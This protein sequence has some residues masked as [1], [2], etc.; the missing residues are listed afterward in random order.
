MA[1]PA[2]ISVELG[3]TGETGAFVLDVSVL[4]GPA[5]LGGDLGFIWMDVTDWVAG[6]LTIS[7]GSGSAQGPYM[8]S[9]GGRC[10]F[11]LES[12]DG[13]FDPTNLSGPYV[14]AGV[15]LLRPGVPVRVVAR[16]SGVETVL[17]VGTCDDWPIVFNGDLNATVPITAS[18]AIEALTA[19]DLPELSSP[20]G[21]GETAA[22]RIDRIL[23]R[24]GWPI[25]QR[26]ISP[27][28]STPLQA[29]SMAQPTWTQILMAADSAGAHAWIS[30]DGKVTVRH[31][32]GFPSAA[33]TT[34]GMTAASV[35]FEQVT[36]EPSPRSRLINS[37]TLGRA[38]S[39]AQFLEDTDSVAKFGRRS[40]GRT[41]LITADDEDVMALATQI[42]S[43]F[44][45][46]Q[47]WQPVKVDLS[48]DE[49]AA[50][51]AA[52]LA[53]DIGDR[54]EIVQST[55]DGRTITAGGIISAITWRIAP[56]VGRYLVSWGL[57]PTP[58]VYTPWILD[59]SK[60]DVD[61]LALA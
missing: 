38:G 50:T 45:T 46:L 43:Q 31:R 35:Q 5:T 60:L 61:Q 55:P 59:T 11:S 26:D 23:D 19:A 2:T 3:L 48:L 1:T 14:A 42:L 22:A 9:G 24:I 12:L 37:V 40:W 33:Q 13:R 41:D 54:I 16:A 36:A 28:A 10:S 8:R 56:A 7:R 57:F 34:V 30:R 29:T 44:A 27:L 17:F 18:D 39:T 20:V 52:A 58:P 49:H 53:R 47:P 32:L 15:T 25:S 4:D 21:A 51:W 6:D